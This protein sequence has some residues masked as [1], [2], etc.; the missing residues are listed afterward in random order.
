MFLPV[1][2]KNMQKVR[3]WHSQVLIFVEQTFLYTWMCKLSTSKPAFG[4]TPTAHYFTLE[5]WPTMP[6][7]KA[8]QIDWIMGSH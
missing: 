2:C 4:Q 5:F 3:A 1:Q 7:Y 6:G 8:I